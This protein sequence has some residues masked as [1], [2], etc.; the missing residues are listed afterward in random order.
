MS[1]A[2]RLYPA[3]P[4]VGI[5]VVVLRD[6]PGAVLLAR[7]GNPPDAGRWSLPGGVQE[8]GETA[9]AAARRELLEETGLTVGTLLLAGQVDSIH[10]DPDGRVRFHYTIIDFA[11]RWCGEAAHPGGDITEVTWAA[12]DRLEDYGLWTEALRIIGLARRLWF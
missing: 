10:R 8:L 5:G 4:L 2:G 12:I 9:E 7:R 1:D 3:R 6:D 11:A